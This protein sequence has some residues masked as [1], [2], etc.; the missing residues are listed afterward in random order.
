MNGC[1]T[2]R[3]E[4]VLRRN[5]CSIFL[6]VFR[7][8]KTQVHGNVSLSSGVNSSQQKTK[9]SYIRF[10]ATHNAPQTD[11]VDQPMNEV[12][13]GLKICRSALALIMRSSYDQILQDITLILPPVR[14][15]FYPV[16]FSI[17]KERMPW[18]TCMSTHDMPLW[19]VID[20]LHQGCD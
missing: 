17:V 8:S 5:F 11:T 15:L 16:L 9:P 6:S 1:Q 10:I 2:S 19:A 14:L 3:D 18:H 12:Q 7:A 13:T 4:N 20:R